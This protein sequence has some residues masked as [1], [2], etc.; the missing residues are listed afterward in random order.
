MYGPSNTV[1]LQ[2][3][4]NAGRPIGTDGME[5]ADRPESGGRGVQVGPGVRLGLRVGVAINASTVAAFS[6][7]MML[8]GP[9]VGTTPGVG[10]GRGTAVLMDTEE[11]A[12]NTIV[13]RMNV[14]GIVRKLASLLETPITIQSPKTLYKNDA[15]PALCVHLLG[16]SIKI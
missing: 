3:A 11:H 16:H 14:D 7:T 13:K 5:E 12:T 9:G 4:V 1:T 15:Q 2:F 10:V 6:T 8:S